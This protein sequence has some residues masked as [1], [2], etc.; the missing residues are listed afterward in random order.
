MIINGIFIK[1]N[2]AARNQQV[3]IAITIG[4]KENAA[5]VF[6]HFY[7]VGQWLVDKLTVFLLYK[8]MARKIECA[9]YKEI[10]GAVV[11]DVGGGNKRT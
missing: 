3:G 11:I 5:E 1:P 9:S 2:I 10:P 8:Q 7:T 4:I 6:F